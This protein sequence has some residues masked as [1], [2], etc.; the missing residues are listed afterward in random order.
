MAKRLTGKE[1]RKQLRKTEEEIDKKKAG[2]KEKRKRM[3]KFMVVKG[4]V[5]RPTK[6]MSKRRRAASKSRKTRGILKAAGIQENY[7]SVGRPAGTYKY[8]MP[9]QE[10]N[11]LKRKRVEQIQRYREAQQM[12]LQ[13]RGISPQQLQQMQL[14]RTIQ[15]RQ[16]PQ[17][18][19]QVREFKKPFKGDG[20]EKS[21]DEELEFNRWR[22][23]EVL[24][25]SAEAILTRLR[26]TQN[27]G[28]MANIRQQRIQEERR[29]ISQ[30]GN[31]MRAH[32]NMIDTTMDFTGV[33]AETNILMAPNVFKESPNNP[34][35]LKTNRPNI[36]QTG[37]TGNRLKF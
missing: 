36:L 17:Q 8:G 7:R 11:Q 14:Q 21:V 20:P 13:R 37:V 10:Y 33:D 27:M 19:Q 30:K 15:E 32:E 12:Q 26:K 2:I 28:K 23:K 16:Q 25:P 22:A 24:S 29:I 9:I 5:K 31:L 34:H 4:G 3:A 18:F 6:K 35:I 1:E